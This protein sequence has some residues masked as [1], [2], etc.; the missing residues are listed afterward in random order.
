MK[1]EN[2]FI[3]TENETIE[4]VKA[5]LKDDIS[6]KKDGI[7]IVVSKNTLIEVDLDR[8]VALVSGDHVDI[9]PDEYQVLHD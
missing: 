1:T 7:E 3:G 2:K 5:Y 6:Y 8:G 9:F 4:T